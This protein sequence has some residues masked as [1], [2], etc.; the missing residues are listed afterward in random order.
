[1]GGR[2]LVKQKTEKNAA[3]PESA[4]NRKS[5]PGN[6]PSFPKVCLGTDQVSGFTREQGPEHRPGLPNQENVR[7][8]WV[9]T[10]MQ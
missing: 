9:V 10:A 3:P 8:K 1:V 4:V 7:K 2:G 5:G 6:I